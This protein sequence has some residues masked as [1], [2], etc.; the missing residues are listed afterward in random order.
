MKVNDEDNQIE[1]S[2]REFV[3][4]LTEKE[5]YPNWIKWER[6]YDILRN[7]EFDLEKRYS[8]M[9]EVSPNK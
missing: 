2:G 7:P 5:K 8:L 3:K 1:G 4:M 9:K 6:V